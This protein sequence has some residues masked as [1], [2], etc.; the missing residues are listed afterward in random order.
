MFTDEPCVRNNH[1]LVSVSPLLFVQESQGMQ[2]LVYDR[3]NIYTV[4]SNYHILPP[5]YSTHRASATDISVKFNIDVSS[6]RTSRHKFDASFC[7]EFLNSFFNVVD[8]ISVESMVDDIGKNP[9][10]PK[11]PGVSENM[12]CNTVAITKKEF[13]LFVCQYHISVM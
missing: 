13:N 6:L 10:W 1:V 12:L 2:Q 8:A 5:A 11:P 4:V 3:V 7:V 9:F